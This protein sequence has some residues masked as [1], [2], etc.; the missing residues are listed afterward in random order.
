MTTD[1]R[2][3][4]ASRVDMSKREATAV[5]YISKADHPV[6]I[7]ELQGV[8]GLSYP[9]TASLTQRLVADRDI[10]IVGR[11]RREYLLAKPQPGN[12][13]GNG[14]ERRVITQDVTQLPKRKIA[15]ELGSVSSQSVLDQLHIGLGGEL[16]VSGFHLVDGELPVLDLR[17]ADGAVLSVTVIQSA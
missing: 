3:N 16:I 6:T 8:L 13:N 15:K 7:K 14:V 4:R 2:R 9:S 10:D 11:N 17:S 5:E 12:G 1:G